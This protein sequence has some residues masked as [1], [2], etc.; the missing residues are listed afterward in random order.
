[1]GNVGFDKEEV[2]VECDPSPVTIP[3]ER[4][5]EPLIIRAALRQRSEKEAHR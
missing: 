2:C 4:L 1:M 5:T 3:R